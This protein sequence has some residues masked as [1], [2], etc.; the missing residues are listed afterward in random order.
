MQTEIIS[1]IEVLPLK[2]KL[3]EP[4]IIS[5]GRLDY[6]DNVIVKITTSS[7]ITGFGEC[8]PFRTIHG[9][10]AE[11]CIV[12]GKLLS[13]ILIGRNA[14]QI[15]ELVTLMDKAIF[16]NTSIKSAFDIAL[17]DI[18][19]QSA[20]LPLYKFL[21]GKK[22]K[23]IHT[24]YT[25]SIDSAEKMA[26]DARKILDAGYP[27]IKVKLGGSPEEDI[28][29]MKSIRQSVGNSIPIR[30]DA[31]Q[32]WSKEDAIYILNEL[33]SL[34]V[35]HCEEPVLKQNFLDLPEIKAASKIP[36]MADESCCDHLDAAR[37]IKIKACDLFN[38]KLGK[39]GG[40]FK[41][42]K[43]LRLCEKNNIDVQVGGFLESRLGFTASAHLAMCSEKVKYFD[44]DT[45][46]MFSEDPVEGGIAYGE[47]GRI[48]LS[49]SSGLGAT[50]NFFN[51]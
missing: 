6:A 3:R 38:I 2:V 4:F 28:F 47:S 50:I 51:N 48:D 18:A 20:G 8:S 37:L 46:L 29:R 11:T 19:S 25:V 22:D 14:L 33:S 26:A 40:I 23:L 9:E 42:L 43:I 17:Y 31:N 34:N 13:E 27:V 5:L 39:S 16:G 12:I 35:Q 36:I 10:T 1:S 15:E 24:D 21:G 41:A 49:E 44:F 45:P 7:G 30:I 32:G